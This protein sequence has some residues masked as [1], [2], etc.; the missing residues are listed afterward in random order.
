MSIFYKFGVEAGDASNVECGAMEMS[1]AELK[2]KIVQQRNI[3]NLTDFDLQIENGQSGKIYTVEEELIPRGTTV[4]VRRVPMPRGEKK[5]WQVEPKVERTKTRG[6]GGEVSS[7]VVTSTSEEGR[8][9]QVLEASGAE[10][11]KDNWERVWRGPRAPRPLAGEPAKAERRYAH[12]IPSNMLV[13]VAEDTSTA[14][15]DRFGGLK[16]TAVE[17]EGYSQEKKESHAWL[18]EKE[19]ESSKEKQEE[20]KETVA[21]PKELQ[22]GFCSELLDAAILLP[23]CVAAAC[24]ECARNSLIEQDHVCK[25]CEEADISPNDLIPNPLLRKKVAAFRGSTGGQIKKVEARAPLTPLPN[26][27]LPAE[28]MLKLQKEQEEMKKKEEEAKLEQRR[29]EEALLAKL[30]SSEQEE[31]ADASEEKPAAE[32]DTAVASPKETEEEKCE[33]SESPAPESEE[34]PSSPA[35][36][37]SSPPGEPDSSTVLPETAVEP[38]VASEEPA[39][40]S[41]ATSYSIPSM[42]PAVPGGSVP[43]YVATVPFYP[44]LYDYS[45]PPP[46][47][48]AATIYTNFPPYGQY[49]GWGRGDRRRRRSRSRSRERDRE[50]YSRDREMERERLG[51]GNW[52]H[53]Q[54]K[55]GGMRRSRT[56]WR[57]GRDRSGERR[58]PRSR[59]R[60]KGRKSRERRRSKSRDK[61]ERS[62]K[63]M[64]RSS[65]T[66]DPRFSD[67]ERFDKFEGMSE[68][69]KAQIVRAKAEAELLANTEPQSKEPSVDKKEEARQKLKDLISKNKERT[70]EVK[71]KDKKPK[72]E[73][74][75]K[76][77]KEKKSKKHKVKE[78][79]NSEQENVR[80]KWER[81]RERAE[82]EK[83]SDGD[84]HCGDEH[85]RFVNF[86]RNTECKKCRRPQPDSP[87][88]WDLPASPERRSENKENPPDESVLEADEPACASPEMDIG[89]KFDTSHSEERRSSRPC[90]RSGHV[91]SFLDDIGDNF[92]PEPGKDD[93][94]GEERRV[95]LQSDN[96]GADKVIENKTT[97]E[98]AIANSQLDEKDVSAVS[99][100]AAEES[101]ET[102]SSQSIIGNSTEEE[103]EI[104][105][106]EAIHEN[107]EE[108]NEEDEGKEKQPNDDM[109]EEVDDPSDKPSSGPECAFDGSK[110][111]KWND[112]GRRSDEFELHLDINDAEFVDTVK[113]EY[114]SSSPSWAD[115][116]KFKYP[117]GGEEKE[118][119]VSVR[120]RMEDEI[121]KE[122]IEVPPKSETVKGR[123]RSGEEDRS[124]EEQ[125][126]MRGG[127][128]GL[129]KERPYR[130]SS[131]DDLVEVF[132]RER[133]E[134]SSAS[135]GERERREVRQRERD[136]KDR[137]RNNR[138]REEDEERKRRAKLE[139]ARESTEKWARKRREEEHTNELR[140]AKKERELKEKKKL[141][142]RKVAEEEENRRRRREEEDLM[143]RQNMLREEKKKLDAEKR[144]IID[145]KRA[146]DE[147]RS[148]EKIAEEKESSK[149]RNRSGSGESSGTKKKV[150]GDLRSQL[151]RK[152]EKSAATK[153]KSKSK[154]KKKKKRESSSS[155]SSSESNN[156]SE[157]ES[158]SDSDIALK[159]FQDKKML[160]KL[161]E[162]VAKNSKKKKSKKKKKKSVKKTAPEQR[163]VVLA[164]EGGS[165]TMQL[166]NTSQEEEDDEMEAELAKYNRKANKILKRSSTDEES[167]EKRRKSKEKEEGDDDDEA[168]SE[169]IEINIRNSPAFKRMNSLKMKKK[170]KKKKDDSS[171]DER[172]N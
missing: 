140:A 53:H 104:V 88:F 128:V 118:K 3:K 159:V 22:C 138:M 165:I 19:G 23:C 119:T 52:E 99:K 45:Q 112:L 161:L 107:Q 92:E 153:K 160:K 37:A 163:R 95:Y 125:V 54:R 25:L 81:E 24:D 65:K 90:S 98:R 87:I 156:S 150:V 56:E 123:R 134:G 18:E 117:G 143:R 36:P 169:R 162:A 130:R 89:L 21:I 86:K 35:E 58:G 51:Y 78:V 73:A 168:D 8:L 20:E 64:E 43:G 39:K 96:D 164:R 14:K 151:D 97:S 129:W 75:E 5:T 12:G 50:R 34:A 142:E 172:S 154:S 49:E 109:N 4:M 137:D 93:G 27:V 67:M 46:G 7:L 60:S 13:P 106:D 57:D 149:K 42:A 68:E 2:I 103:K 70:K 30:M 108:K 91:T 111:H 69:E 146:S 76:K 1:L 80:D 127:E 85:C 15:V 17:R 47:Y 133:R 101:F 116:K 16:L 100:I 38:T 148:R 6:G 102:I 29:L 61:R 126:K 41:I 77:D 120:R 166:S 32:E 139:D 74:R 158:D 157:S 122:D 171:S 10:Y 48:P 33:K 44:S 144:A 170:Q 114:R 71:E 84:W 11:G 147:R 94:M 72:K 40:D 136:R 79:G 59:S 105:K 31:I 132:E 155:E 141:E 131:K 83:E 28:T 63:S 135:E 124:E 82:R 145:R 152:K 9:D 113:A 62:S 167:G 55:H 110:K 66:P 121:K 26:A 115:S